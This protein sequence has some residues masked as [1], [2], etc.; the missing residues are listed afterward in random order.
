M[1]KRGRDLT[2]GNGSHDEKWF[3]SMPNRFGQRR[4]RRVIGQIVSTGKKTQKR[5]AS[6]RAM[7]ANG[8]AQN[9]ITGFHGIEHG[10]HRNGTVHLQ[11]NLV[12]DTS[13]VAQ[14]K[15][16]PHANQASSPFIF[17]LHPHSRS[18]CTSTDSTAG[19]SRTI[20]CQESPPSGETYTCPPVVPKYTPLGS[21]WSTAIASRR[22]FT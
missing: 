4:I 7:L 12:I 11:H 18:V 8:T 2:S 5:P 10:G 22:T 3:I 17:T 9:R 21:S 14:M 6:L 1:G 19:R 13:K 20:A 16:Q 15:R